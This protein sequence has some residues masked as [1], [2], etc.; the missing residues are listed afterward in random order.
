MRSLTFAAVG[1]VAGLAVC[2]AV[3][4]VPVAIARGS[5]FMTAPVLS[6]VMHRAEGMA[7]PFLTAGI[8]LAL[9]A[10]AIKPGEETLARLF[11]RGLGWHLIVPIVGFLAMYVGTKNN[12]TATAFFLFSMLGSLSSYVARTHRKSFVPAEVPAAVMEDD[13]AVLVWHPA[14]GRDQVP[15]PD[16]A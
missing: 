13:P 3:A 2:A 10:S 11:L 1:A 7:A 12:S 15:G 9:V 8:L 5:S 16:A 14:W 6:S 4:A